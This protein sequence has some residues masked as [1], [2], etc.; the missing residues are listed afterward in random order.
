MYLLCKYLV[1]FWFELREIPMNFPLIQNYFLSDKSSP[2]T[3]ILSFGYAW[4]STVIAST[5]KS[6]A[7]ATTSDTS[8]TISL[9]FSTLIPSFPAIVITGIISPI[10]I[11]YG[12]YINRLL[13]GFDIYAW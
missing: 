2:A 5:G 13:K 6:Y 12:D 10:K 8:L 4:T 7:F 9:F 3:P 11:Y 1:L